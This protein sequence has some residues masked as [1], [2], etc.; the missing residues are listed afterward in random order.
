MIEMADAL[1]RPTTPQDARVQLTNAPVSEVGP[2]QIFTWGKTP[3][4]H[5]RAHGFEWD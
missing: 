3:E 1:S 4:N 5:F 2:G